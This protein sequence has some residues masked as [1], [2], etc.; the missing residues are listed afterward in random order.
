MF[1]ANRVLQYFAFDL[2]SWSHLDKTDTAEESLEKTWMLDF[3]TKK[4]N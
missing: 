3:H 2:G 4:N 1:Q